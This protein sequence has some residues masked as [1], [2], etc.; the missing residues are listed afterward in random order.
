M[1]TAV[2]M[3]LAAVFIASA[4]Q[5][6]MKMGAL[7]GRSGSLLRSFLDPL[8]VAGYTLML[9]ST[10]V[11]TIAL[12]TLPLHFTVSLQPIG[13]I[14]IIVLSATILRERMRRHHLW[15][16]LLIL[17]GIVIFNMGTL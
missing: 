16:M 4:G 7:R 12:K 15:G 17:V 1:T 5:L 2:A 11:A 6:L 3:F 14:I 8:T 13:Y 10:V 9:G